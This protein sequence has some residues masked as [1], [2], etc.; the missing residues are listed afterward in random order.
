M[1]PRADCQFL[2]PNIKCDFAAEVRKKKMAAR[3]GHLPGLS[4]GRPGKFAEVPHRNFP[5][6]SDFLNCVFGSKVVVSRRQNDRFVERSSWLVPLF[7]ILFS[8]LVDL[9]GKVDGFCAEGLR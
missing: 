7:S 8:K 9:R 2:E 5:P 3:A 6:E 4:E 1:R